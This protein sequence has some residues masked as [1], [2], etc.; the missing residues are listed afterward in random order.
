MLG[1]S[2]KRTRGASS[3]PREFYHLPTSA[4]STRGW[5]CWPYA[6][7]CGCTILQYAVEPG[8]LGGAGTLRFTLFTLS[9]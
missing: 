7:R 3:M 6:V 8:V 2:R 1:F 9:D 4:S 5:A